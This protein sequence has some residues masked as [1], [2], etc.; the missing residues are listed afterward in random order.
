VV[1]DAH[2]QMKAE[3]TAPDVAES[4]GKPLAPA[5]DRDHH[6]PDAA[7]D[8]GGFTTSGGAERPRTLLVTQA[9]RRAFEMSDANAAPAGHNSYPAS[10]SNPTVSSVMQTRGGSLNRGSFGL[11]AIAFEAAAMANKA[12]KAAGAAGNYHPQQIVIIIFCKIIHSLFHTDSF[13]F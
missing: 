10:P 13:T 6:I 3:A 7:S 4:C 9:A 2:K 8:N 1:S 12:N 11:G 5:A